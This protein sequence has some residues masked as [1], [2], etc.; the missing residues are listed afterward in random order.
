[1]KNDEL[2]DAPIIKGFSAAKNVPLKAKRLKTAV[3]EPF[4]FE[5]NRRLGL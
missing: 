3:F 1:M 4:Y 2:R 5:N